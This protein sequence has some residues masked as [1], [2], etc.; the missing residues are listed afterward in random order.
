MLSADEARE[1]AYEVLGPTG[2]TKLPKFGLD[3]YKDPY[4]PE[5]LFFEATR[6]NPEAVSGVIGHYAVNPKTKDVWEVVAC[7]RLAT[8]SLRKRQDTIRKRFRFSSEE[9]RKLKTKKPC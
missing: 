2:V 1:L 3:Q 9:Y 5:F 6:E 8:P 4:F 7:K